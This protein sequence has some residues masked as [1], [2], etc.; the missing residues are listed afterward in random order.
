MFEKI[1]SVVEKMRRKWIETGQDML[2]ILLN[3]LVMVSIGVTAMGM[4][5]QDEHEVWLWSVLLAI[6]I[7]FYWAQL[8][9]HNFFLYYALHLA[10]PI[11]SIFLPVQIVAKFVMVF[12]SMVYFV[13]S[14]KIGI[15][16]RGRGEGVIGPIYMIVALGLMVLIETS[17]SQRG[18]EGVYI[19]IALIYA[20]GYCMYIY[21]SQYLDFLIVNENSVE[22]IPEVEI[23]N[24]GFCQAFTYIVG[25]VTFLALTAK[26]GWFS[27]IDSWIVSG[28]ENIFLK[29]IK[30]LFLKE[31][32]SQE[33][34]P[35]MSAEQD[36]SE[37][38][39]LSK[40][41][42]QALFLEI[43]EKTIF[44]SA[45]VIVA[46]LLVFGLRYLWKEFHKRTVKE[47]KK[48]S[49]GIDIRETCTIEKKKREGNNW[50]S[51]L[52]NSEKIRKIYRKQ[53]SKNKTAIIGD[54]QAEALE[55]LTAKEC[56]DKFAAEQLKKMYEKTRY[57]RE[58]ITSDDVRAAK[59]GR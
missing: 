37:L 33:M 7:L 35:M 59:S 1:E 2:V 47:E 48:L 42:E 46:V 21:L 16:P 24:K 10:V 22:N 8:K 15:K 3:H 54:L 51:F 53:V 43:L 45:I 30:F 34:P 6:P 58:E 55:Y 14:V 11:V 40:A 4:L 13:W 29:I 17:Y 57:S 20:S 18:W 50:F 56:C 38:E 44:I 25:V 49:G 32:T 12:I 23:F 36:L 31:E 28:T 52:N 5:E 39:R 41:S 19:A 9:L 27:Y 26:V